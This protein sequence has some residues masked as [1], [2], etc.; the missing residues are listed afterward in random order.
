M[1]RELSVLLD[2]PAEILVRPYETR[3]AA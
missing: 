3:S 1:V 2:I